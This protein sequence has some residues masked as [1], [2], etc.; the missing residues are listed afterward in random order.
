V[1]DLYRIYLTCQR[2][3]VDYNLAYIPS[4]FQ[5]PH[6]EELDTEYMRALYKTAYDMAAKGY[7]WAKTPPG[8]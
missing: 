4:S 3:G 5:A 8:Y 2:D 1:G 7:P 6:K